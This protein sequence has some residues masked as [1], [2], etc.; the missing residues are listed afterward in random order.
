MRFKLL[1]LGLAL[2]QKSY[3][4]QILVPFKA[5]NKFGLANEAGKVILRPAYDKLNWLTGAYFE[6][7]NEIL[8]NDT[9]ETAPNRFYIRNEKVLQ[10][11]LLHKNKTI[12]KAGAYE[13]FEI[14]PNKCIVAKNTRNYNSLTKE[15]YAVLK[16]KRNEKSVSLFTLNGENVFPDNFRSL[17][18]F[19]TAGK[20]TV[21]KNASKYILFGAENFDNQ[22]SFFVFDTD[23]QAIDTW[24]LK[25][26]YKLKIT[27]ADYGNKIIRLRYQDANSITH[28][29][30][31]SWSAGSFI[32]SDTNPPAEKWQGDG[33]GNGHS[34]GSGSGKHVVAEEAPVEEGERINSTL[35]QQ[36]ADSIRRQ[37]F[38]PF[39]QFKNDSLFHV[40]YPNEMAYIAVDTTHRLLYADEKRKRQS[41]P[42]IYQQQQKFG[43]LQPNGFSRPLY[44]SLVYFGSDYIAAIKKHEQLQFG[45][46]D[47][48]GNIIVPFEYDS[49]QI[50]LQQ[51][52]VSEGKDSIKY[53]ALKNKEEWRSGDKEIK[54]PYFLKTNSQLMVF[55]K[56]KWG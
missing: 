36:M 13:R 1:F 46:I 30:M 25:N 12:L 41:Q 27:D 10:K 20:S 21:S 34:Y 5:G 4:Q 14:I 56:E 39:F 18:K 47:G 15:Q 28:Y 9:L 54:R 19:D 43:L 26:V 52:V 37:R 48:K 35:R 29:K 50:G 44:D 6:T 31:L 45:L 42:I 55:K 33:Y 24:L 22:Y 11:G 53:Y 32:I 8:L 40:T 49:I 51:L 38:V 23:K 3:S 16:N 17:Q 2:V 7:V